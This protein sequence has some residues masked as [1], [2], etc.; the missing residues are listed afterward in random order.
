[1]NEK[2]LKTSGADIL[3]SRKNLR[4]T[5]RVVNLERHAMLYGWFIRH[6]V[7]FGRRELIL[8]F[9]NATGSPI[10]RLELLYTPL[11]SINWLSL[12]VC[13][14]KF[15][16]NCHHQNTKSCISCWR[17]DRPRVQSLENKQAYFCTV[18]KTCRRRFPRKCNHSTSHRRFSWI[19]YSPPQNQ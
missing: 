8:I 16:N 15:D 1:M 6:F 9:G 3:S 18:D 10:I 12:Y 11:K 5:L 7:V 4:K 17:Y 19:P 13:Y 2:L 14:R